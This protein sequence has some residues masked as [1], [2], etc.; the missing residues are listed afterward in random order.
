MMYPQPYDFT[1]TLPDYLEVWVEF[2]PAS[3]RAGMTFWCHQCRATNVSQVAYRVPFPERCLAWTRDV[4]GLCHA[5]GFYPELAQQ[6]TMQVLMAGH[7]ANVIDSQREAGK[8]GI[9]SG[10]R[11]GFTI[12]LPWPGPGIVEDET[13]AE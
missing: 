2:D 7:L 1:M 9:V 12:P 4:W 6:R 8:R 3:H 13:G 11:V 10:H 5:C